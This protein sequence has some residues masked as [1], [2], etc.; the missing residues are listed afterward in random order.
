MRDLLF[1]D[2]LVDLY[3][4]IIEKIESAKGM[5]FNI[6]GGGQNCASLL[7]VLEVFQKLGYKP[8]KLIYK[9]WRPGDQKIYISDISLANKI[10]RWKPKIDIR[11]GIENLFN[12]IKGNI[13]IIK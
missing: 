2:D 8:F 4:I 9:D 6:G 12:W 13:E 10:L 3:E 1:V 5:A 7:Q 11:E